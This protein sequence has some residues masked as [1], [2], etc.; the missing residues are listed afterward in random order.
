[1]VLT[2]QRME[3]ALYVKHLIKSAGGD[4]G[5]VETLL[6]HL[7][8]ADSIEKLI[9]FF[10]ALGKVLGLKPKLGVVT[11]G[12]NFEHQKLVEDA[13]LEVKHLMFANMRDYL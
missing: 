13:G 9:T 10:P 3:T 8:G 4:A 12:C 5:H 2:P 1:M 11:I 6:P 7:A